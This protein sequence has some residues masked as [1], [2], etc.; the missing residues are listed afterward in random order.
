MRSL[1]TTLMGKV[2]DLKTQDQ[3]GEQYWQKNVSP[4]VNQ[5][6]TG[7]TDEKMKNGDFMMMLPEEQSQM[8]LT[9]QNSVN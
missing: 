8:L 7:L 9:T 6:A 2:D 5:M 4:H 1:V 3:V